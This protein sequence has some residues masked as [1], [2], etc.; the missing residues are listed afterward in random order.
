MSNLD[1]EKKWGMSK[2]LGILLFFQCLLVIFGTLLKISAIYSILVNSTSFGVDFYFN[3]IPQVMSL[4][5]FISIIYYSIIGYKKDDIFY[6]IG[7]YLNI[8]LMLIVVP[9]NLFVNPITISFSNISN[10]R[11]PLQSI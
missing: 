10:P 2:S 6:K 1:F 5:I 4:I 7:I 9:I 8:I 11:W 3:L